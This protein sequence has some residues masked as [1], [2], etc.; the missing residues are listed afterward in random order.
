LNGSSSSTRLLRFSANLSTLFLERAALQRPQAARDAGFSAV[1]IQF[2]YEH[3]SDDWARA[4]ADAGVELALIN[5]PVGD[6]LAGGPGLAAMPGRQAEFRRALTQARHYAERLSPR[7]LNILAGWPPAELGR[8]ACMRVLAGNL[9]LAAEL[10]A[11]IGVRVLVEAVNTRDRPGYLIARSDEALEAIDR[12]GH[13]NLGLQYDLYHMQVME[14]DLTR[15]LQR[16]HAR[17]GH[18]QFAD[19]P[20]RH[21]PGTGEIDFA[22]VFEVIDALGYEGFVGAEYAPSRVTEETLG[23]LRLRRAREADASR[24]TGAT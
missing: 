14:G 22:H 5:A 9:R 8:E 23:W 18:I 19:H 2:P 17:I 12:A 6:L 10:M 24:A 11:D 3:R 16:L 13:A 4:I 15:T 20:G 1:E 21:E 7:N